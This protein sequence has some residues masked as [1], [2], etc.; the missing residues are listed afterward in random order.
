MT[1]QDA[2]LAES[3]RPGRADVVLPDHLQHLT[4]RVARHA[5][6][7]RERQRDP[8]PPR[9]ADRPEREKREADPQRLDPSRTGAE[10]RPEVGRAPGGSHVPQPRCEVGAEEGG[11]Q[12]GKH[13]R[14][15]QRPARRHPPQGDDLHQPAGQR[16]EH[17]HAEPAER[18]RHTRR[19]VGAGRVGVTSGG[20][21]RGGRPERRDAVGRPGGSEH[22]EPVGPFDG[23]PVGGDHPPVDLVFGGCEVRQF[24]DQGPGVGS[25]GP[26]LDLQR[27]PG[28]PH[29]DLT[30]PGLDRLAEDEANDG[31]ARRQRRAV[32]RDRRHQVR[33]DERAG[34]Q[35]PRGDQGCQRTPA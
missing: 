3:F 11:R 27:V 18:G 33:V 17:E 13:E 7:E 4:A 26:H 12:R 10:R 32:L 22:R 16:D 28:R 8:G 5:R 34:Q 30:E 20:A 29:D 23:M 21:V 35:D 1:V 2:A 9:E 15:P 6:R 25:V 19:E 31:R 14:G 24:A